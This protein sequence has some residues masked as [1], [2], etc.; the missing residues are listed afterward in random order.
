MHT[1][2]SYSQLDLFSQCPRRWMYRYIEKIP[3]NSDSDA[4]IYGTAV[5]SLLE[6]LFLEKKDGKVPDLTTAL[7]PLKGTPLYEEAQEEIRKF[8]NAQGFYQPFFQQGVDILGVE[9]PFTLRIPTVIHEEEVDVLIRGYID[10]IYRDIEGIHVVDHKT[11]KRF[12][13]KKK[14][15]ENLQLP[16]Y[17]WAVEELFGESPVDGIYHF[18]RLEDT[19]KALYTPRLTQ[20]MVDIMDQRG[21]KTIWAKPIKRAKQEIIKIVKQMNNDKARQ[22]ACPTPLCYWCSFKEICP[23]KSP[24]QPKEKG[25]L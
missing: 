7:V 16:I 15:R 21:A 12:F 20:E 3:E 1:H 6:N 14:R 10:L 13:Q 19:Q 23:H 11:G 18:T 4:L 22:K 24:W 25:T 9:T 2:V 17:F 8:Q 5:H